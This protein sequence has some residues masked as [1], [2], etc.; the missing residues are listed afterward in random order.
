MGVGERRGRGEG[1]EERGVKGEGREER[2]GGREGG[3]SMSWKSVM[4]YIMSTINLLTYKINAFL[5]TENNIVLII[6]RLMPI[7][8]S[9]AI[10]NVFSST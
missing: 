6:L 2:G 7:V 1:R 10:Y 3:G 8:F 4:S 5:C 9:S